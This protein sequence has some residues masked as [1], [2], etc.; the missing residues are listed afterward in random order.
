MP[1]PPPRLP[2]GLRSLRLLPNRQHLLSPLRA[3]S[4]SLWSLYEIYQHDHNPLL[5]LPKHRSLIL[6]PALR[7]TR[8]P[9]RVSWYSL[10]TRVTGLLVVGKNY[11]ALLLLRGLQSVGGSI[12]SLEYGCGGRDGLLEEGPLLAP[13]MTATD[14]G[15]CVGPVVGGGASLAFNDPRQCF[16]ALPQIRALGASSYRLGHAPVHNWQRRGTRQ[17]NLGEPGGA[18]YSKAQHT[19][20]CRVASPQA[21]ERIQEERTQ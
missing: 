11:S 14:I 18:G 12:I 19:D 10:H 5:R 21:G 9:P 1:A 15:P 2:P 6:V 13:M 17:G 20:T 16:R 7:L 3:P 8:S 4:H